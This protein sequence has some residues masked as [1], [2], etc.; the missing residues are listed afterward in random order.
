MSS[1]IVVHVPE[2]AASLP[3]A[4]VEPEGDG[5]GD[6]EAGL[7]ENILDAGVFDA[8]L[9]HFDHRTLVRLLRVCRGW[10]MLI[11]PCETVWRCACQYLWADKAYVPSHIRALVSEG[12][13]PNTRSDLKAL[14]SADLKKRLR[15]GGL[16]PYQLAPFLSASKP[17]LVSLLMSREA[18]RYPG[19]P[20]AKRALR[21]SLEDANRQS[22]MPDE[23]ISFEWHVRVRGSGAFRQ[24]APLDP[25]WNN[26]GVGG[27]ARFSQEQR[28]Q[29][30]DFI[31][32]PGRDPFELFNLRR[33]AR[34]VWDLEF[35]G[36]IVQLSLGQWGPR[37]T[38]ARHPVTWG[39]V[40]VDSATV[41]TSWPM[42][43][44]GDD[45]LLED[46]CVNQL[47]QASGQEVIG[48]E[49]ESDEDED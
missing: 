28:E 13:D 10:L 21:L 48:D 33:D 32:P 31:W 29:H 36:K 6:Y 16:T 20:L 18:P 47:V 7:L 46:D 2:H 19:E 8:V 34:C 44:R 43:A 42:P 25:W 17:E 1:T 12:N 38:V 26:A 15:A 40:L 45:I 3:G 22:L 4:P 49:F 9:T 5:K 27:R 23:L 11:D 14:S 41:W 39:F 30:V 35:G 24:L 37:Q